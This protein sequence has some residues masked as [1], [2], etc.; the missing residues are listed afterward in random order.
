MIRSLFSFALVA[1]LAAGAVADELKDVK[2]VMNHKANAKADASVE[3]MG[4]KVYFCCNNC[5]GKFKADPEKHAT[6]ANFQ[7]VATKQYKQKACPFSGQAVADDVSSKI[8]KVSVGFCCNN[9]K[10]K[11][12]GG[13]DDAAKAKMVFAK[14]A[15][16]KGFEP[17]K[18]DD[19][20]SLKNV[21]CFMMGEEVSDEFFAEYMGAKVYFCCESCIEEF[22]EETEKY[23]AEANMQ[24]V[25]TKQFTQTGCPMSG[26]KVKDGTHIKVGDTKV[27]FCC[28]NCKAKVEGAEDTEAKMKLVFNKDA[29]KK[30]FKKTKT[31]DDD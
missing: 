19:D 23:A 4:G 11:V 20:N 16:K 15:F 12:D 13:E 6:P 27:G 10:S 21:K 26:G 3:Y 17:V 14:A 29:F 28:P 24:L 18:D 2:C 25:S 7:L 1:A 9:C 8:G 5:A 30:G 31:S 22:N